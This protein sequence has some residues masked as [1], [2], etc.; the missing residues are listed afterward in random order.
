MINVLING[1]NGNMGKVVKKY[2]DYYKIMVN[3]IAR[4]FSVMSNYKKEQDK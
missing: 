3:D 2:I 4:F 1:S